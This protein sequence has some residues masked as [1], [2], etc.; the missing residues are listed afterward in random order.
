MNTEVHYEQTLLYAKRKN[1]TR[2]KKKSGGEDKGSTGCHA[3]T[4]I[5]TC[6]L[7]RAKLIFHP[8]GQ[9]YFPL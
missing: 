8:R 7:S 1:D 3:F 4:G 5:A 9:R 6:Q 2:S